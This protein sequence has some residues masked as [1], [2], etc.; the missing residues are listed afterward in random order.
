MFNNGEETIRLRGDGS[1]YASGNLEVGGLVLDGDGTLG[2]LRLY[3]PEDG[4]LS[5]GSFTQE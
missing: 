5:M 4:D 3:L 1:V 2:S